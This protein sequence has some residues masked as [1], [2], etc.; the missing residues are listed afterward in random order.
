M[1]QGMAGKS[2]Y[3]LAVE[4]GYRGTEEE[5]LESLKGDN[6]TTPKLEIKEDGYW[7]ISYDGGQM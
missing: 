3:E 6:G 4:K 7:Y 5:W 1:A 2:T